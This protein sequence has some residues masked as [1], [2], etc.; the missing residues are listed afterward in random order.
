VLIS[1]ERCAALPV[2]KP[3][4]WSTSSV[5]AA[6]RQWRSV[7]KKCT[8][9]GN[10]VFYRGLVWFNSKLLGAWSVMCLRTK[11]SKRT[12]HELESYVSSHNK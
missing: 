3:G 8:R 9:N 6:S 12:L 2:L 7:I 10:A 11:H 1:S 5:R 4:S